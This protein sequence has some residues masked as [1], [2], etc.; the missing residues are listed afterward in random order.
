MKF[1]NNLTFLDL[2]QLMLIFLKLTGQ[3]DHSWW[4]VFIPFCLMLL[5]GD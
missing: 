5:F 4:I 2:L 3:F 1:A